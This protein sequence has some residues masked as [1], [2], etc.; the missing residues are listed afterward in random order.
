MVG[1]EARTA[2]HEVDAPHLS[3]PVAHVKWVPHELVVANDYNPNKVA[4]N[5][6]RLLWLS[7]KSD[8]YTQPVVTIYNAERHLWE[9][10]DGFHRCLVMKRYDDIRAMTGGLLPIV[11]IDKPMADRMAST[12]RHNRARGKH[13]VS[14]MSQIVFG[15]LD[16]GMDDVE[17]CGELGLTPDELLRLKHIT[18]FSKL[19]ADVEYNRA[20][21]TRRMIQLRRDWEV[22]HAERIEAEHNADRAF[23]DDGQVGT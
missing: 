1:P 17:V 21:Q 5:E 6:L 18:G 11:E 2:G 16:S 14:G 9:I 10:V 8:G 3:Q 22:N 13:S 20:W 4:K 12:V 7:I 15:M 19:F 23:L